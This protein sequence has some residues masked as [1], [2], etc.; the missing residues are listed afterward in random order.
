[1]DLQRD[2]LGDVLGFATSYCFDSL[3]ASRSDSNYGGNF[4]WGGDL[5][6]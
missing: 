2:T 4:Y 3:T 6:F 5:L 1:M